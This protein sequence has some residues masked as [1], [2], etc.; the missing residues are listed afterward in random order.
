MTR[1]A[2]TSSNV[3]SIGYADGVL[4]VEF[5]SG[6]VHAY[7]DVPADAHAALIAAPSIGK[8][9]ATFIRGKFR[10]EK[11]QAQ[12]SRPVRGFDAVLEESHGEIATER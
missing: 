5:K 11:L 10:S 2:V 12:D 3:K 8:H 7:Y 6:A 1:Q 9:Y 4:H